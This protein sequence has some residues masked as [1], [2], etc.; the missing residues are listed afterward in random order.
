MTT[1]PWFLLEELQKRLD[2]ATVS[3]TASRKLALNLLSDSATSRPTNDTQFD[4][5]RPRI[6]TQIQQALSYNRY[7]AEAIVWQFTLPGVTVY[8]NPSASRQAIQADLASAQHAAAMDWPTQLKSVQYFSL[9]SLQPGTTIIARGSDIAS[10]VASLP[11]TRILRSDS[12]SNMGIVGI[13]QQILWVYTNPS[14]Q[15]PVFRITLPNAATLLYT[16]LQLLPAD[17]KGNVRTVKN[18]WWGCKD[19]G[20]RLSWSLASNHDIEI[21]LTRVRRLLAQT[22]HFRITE[23]LRYLLRVYGYI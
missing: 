2:T 7:Q 13:D 6:E 22:E 17:S 3:Q 21:I 11:N 15:S 8:P 5:F 20:S 9:A 23:A 10:S 4:D 1:E 19:A 18:R 12:F 14:A 16:F